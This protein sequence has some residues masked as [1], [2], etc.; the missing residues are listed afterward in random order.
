MIRVH[1]IFY[2][3]RH[4]ERIT[5]WRSRGGDVAQGDLVGT[6]HMNAR[7]VITCRLKVV[8]RRAVQAIQPADSDDIPRYRHEIDDRRG[9]RIGSYGRS[10]RERTEWLAGHP[11]HLNQQVTSCLMHPIQDLDARIGA[12]AF[13][14]PFPP[15][16]EFDSAFR[17]G[18][19]ATPWTDVARCP[20]SSDSAN[21][22]DP[23]VQLIWQRGENFAWP[24]SFI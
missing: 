9:D 7:R 16:I 19:I 2:D 10:Q 13:Q 3:F 4:G 24:D 20:G 17:P 1:S 23:G 22:I 21:K 12:E 11:W 15:K 6:L 18:W 14:G 8:Q 5:A